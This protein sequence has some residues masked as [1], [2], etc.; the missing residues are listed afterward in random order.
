MQLAFL[1]YGALGMLCGLWLA[2]GAGGIT[3]TSLLATLNGIVSLGV[4]AV[5]QSRG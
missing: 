1:L 3:D 4:A 5:L 2:L